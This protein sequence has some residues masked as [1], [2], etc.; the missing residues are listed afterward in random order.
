MILFATEL[1]LSTFGAVLGSVIGFAASASSAV[2]IF[3]RCIAKY[4]PPANP[5]FKFT[6][7]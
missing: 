6:F 1:C 4:I 3:K 2:Y 7:K 5:D